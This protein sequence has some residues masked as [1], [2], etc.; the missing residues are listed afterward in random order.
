MNA[1]VLATF[2]CAFPAPE[3]SEVQKDQA[4]FAGEWRVLRIDGQRKAQWPKEWSI[5]KVLTIQDIRMTPFFVTEKQAVMVLDPSQSPRHID[6]IICPDTVA[7]KY[8]YAFDGD[9]LKLGMTFDL[10]LLG[11]EAGKMRPKSFMIDDD[12]SI[13]VFVLERVKKGGQP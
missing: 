5:P 11:G 8:I 1:L 6:A 2:T 3:P 10:A 13:L 4:K 7:Q 12:P 9:N